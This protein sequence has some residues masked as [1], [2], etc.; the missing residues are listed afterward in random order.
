MNFDLQRVAIIAGG[1]LIPGQGK[2][3]VTGVSTDTRTVREGD[4]FVPLCGDTFD[5]HDFLPQAQQKGAAACLSQRPVAGL[6]L[7]IVQVKDT[8]QALGNLARAVRMGFGGPVVAVTGSSGK[9]TTKEMLSAILS[10]TAP[11]LKTKG[12]YNNLIGLPLTLFGLATGDA[13][14]V[15]EMGMSARGEIARLC[16]IARPTVGIV[17]NVGPAHLE[18]LHGLEGVARAKG[19][20]FADL[21]PGGTAIVNADDERVSCLPVANGVDRVLFGFSGRAQVRAETV[22][23]EGT[24]V[25][26]RLCLPGGSWP[27]H[28]AAPGH[29]NVANALAAAAAASVLEAAPEQIVAGLESFRP[30]PG[31]MAVEEL[32]GGMTLLDDSYNANPLSVEAA[33]QVLGE[34]AGKGRRIAILGDM[35]ELGDDA[36]EM[37]REVGSEA[38]Q[39]ADLLLAMGDLAGEMVAGAIAAGMDSGCALQLKGHDEAVAWIMKECRSG[40]SLLVKGSRGMKMERICQDLR[41]QGGR[42]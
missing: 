19:E 17:T 31:R 1:S 6:Q 21:E 33:L 20:L 11:G 7:P 9:T 3:R 16:E 39:R 26:F 27:V 18:S 34:L 40:D 5:G 25:N 13:W 35:L 23:I 29:H 32:P 12:N 38:A 4:L 8:L 24:E 28:L 22:S 37:H 30:A 36:A 14:I 41:S 15:L 42:G 10:Q 2:V